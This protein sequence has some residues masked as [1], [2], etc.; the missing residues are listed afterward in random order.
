VHYGD[1]TLDGLYAGML[2]DIPHSMGRGGWTTAAF[3]DERADEDQFNA[4]ATIHAGQAGGS[5]SLLSL[6]VSTHLGAQRKP[7]TYDGSNKSKSFRIPGVI[8]GV[9][10]PIPGGDR[11]GDTVITNSGYW[12]A[13]EIVV[14]K[15]TR[16]KLKAFGRV[17]DFEGRSAEFCRI[18][19]SGP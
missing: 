4:L 5:T 1:V 17:W 3:I 10:E 18:E 12:I 16:A 2:L 11:S 8:D 7:I 9:I 6:L 19:W 13:P 15:A 14:A